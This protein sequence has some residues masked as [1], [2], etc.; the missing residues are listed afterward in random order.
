MSQFLVNA[1]AREGQELLDPCQFV[2]GFSEGKQ[3]FWE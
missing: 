1:S 2:R 3:G